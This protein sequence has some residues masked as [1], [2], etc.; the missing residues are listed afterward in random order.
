MG[1]DLGSWRILILNKFFMKKFVWQMICD[2]YKIWVC[3]V[4]AKCFS[5]LPSIMWKLHDPQRI[6][7]FLKENKS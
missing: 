3:I 7:Y 1:V 4:R 6:K 5:Y 2:S